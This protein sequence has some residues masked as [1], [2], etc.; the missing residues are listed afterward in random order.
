MLEPGDAS[1][2][3]QVLTRNHC[4]ER[5]KA[6]T[7]YTGRMAHF[8]SMTLAERLAR[9]TA[10]P[11]ER[12][13][14]EWTGKRNKQGYGDIKWRGKT[15]RVNRLTWMDAHGPIPDGMQVLHTCDNPPCR[16]LEH[17]FLGTPLANMRDKYAKGRENVAK[18]QRVAG[19]KLTPDMVRTIR[20]DHRRLADIAADYSVS[21][22]TINRVQLGQ[23]WAHVV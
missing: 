18:G 8:A 6:M 12:G 19:A 15:W 13:C 4:S 3:A 23:C 7:K 16:T 21:R 1:N 17:L 2:A 11:N 22:S 5:L 14:C 20:S 10:P 9:Y